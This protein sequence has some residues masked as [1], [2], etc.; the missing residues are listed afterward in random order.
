MDNEY[1]VTWYRIEGVDRYLLW[2]NG[3]DDHDGVLVDDSRRVPSFRTPDEAER[4]ARRLGLHFCEEKPLLIDL[5][6][7]VGWLA[8]PQAEDIDCSALLGAFNLFWDVSLSIGVIGSEF[9]ALKQEAV[10]NKVYDRLFWGTNPPAL[11]PL[12]KH[13][14]PEWDDI[15]IEFLSVALGTGLDMFRKSMLAEDKD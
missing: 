5:D 9:L 2:R 11:T 3:G 14:V 7:V 13:F 10:E 8:K 12:G 6:V 4:A 15:D 1:Y